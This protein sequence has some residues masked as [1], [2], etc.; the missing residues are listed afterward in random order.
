MIGL[1]LAAMLL[2]VAGP[3]AAEYP[4]A[5]VEGE[6]LIVPAA[7][8]VKFTRL[9]GHMGRFAGQF[10]LTGTLVYGCRVDC[11]R[12]LQSPDLQLYVEPDDG[13]ARTL[14]HWKI[15][16]DRIRIY[17]D[18]ERKLAATVISAAERRALLTKRR[19]EVRKRVS[20][21]I[22][23]FRLGIDCDSA[24]YFARF[25]ALAAPPR[26]AKSREGEE[27]GCS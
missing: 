12:P 3:G 1:R 13:Q 14:P 2:A 24:S 4:L 9:D 17:F 25:V 20:L 26:L 16:T 6:A 18:N 23:D 21:L 11:D 15:R 8:P 19:T 5:D 10:T 22:D 27:S 7:S